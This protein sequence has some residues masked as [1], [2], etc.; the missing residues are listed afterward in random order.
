M[1]LPEVKVRARD[2]LTR[3]PLGHVIGAEVGVARGS[4]SVLL[5]ERHD[6]SLYMV[7]S[8][9]PCPGFTEEQ[10]ELNQVEAEEATAFA[11]SRRYIVKHDSVKA[12]RILAGL[13]FVFI[14]AAHDYENVKADIAA[15]LPSI[16]RPGILSGHD[17]L[18]TCGVKQAVDEAAAE[19]NWRLEFGKNT[20]WFVRLQ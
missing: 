8:Y 13:D 19:H 18:D 16:K 1:R 14:D 7:D 20:T 4:L 17:Y 15:W 2:I 9:P 3:L 11:Q 5:L 10:Q 12:A 6:L